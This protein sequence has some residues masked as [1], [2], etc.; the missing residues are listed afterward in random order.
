[1]IT[2]RSEEKARLQRLSQLDGL[3]NIANR[4]YFDVLLEREVNR[5]RRNK[6]PI[7][8]LL[9][10]IDNFKQYN[11]KY[12][13]LAGDDCLKQVAVAAARV[14]KRPGDLIARFGGEEFA[15]LLPET[16]EYGAQIV[17]EQIRA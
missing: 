2:K 17:A 11:D 1:D 5:A 3:T 16:D 12:G 4:R 7:A 13:H 9:F 14:L 6:L 10:D 15:V 8:M